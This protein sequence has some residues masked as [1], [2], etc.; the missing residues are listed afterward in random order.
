[1]SQGISG[2]SAASSAAS[3]SR[4]SGSPWR[5]SSS[6][7]QISSSCLPAITLP[8]SRAASITTLA[9]PRPQ[10]ISARS[11]L[12]SVVK[13]GLSCFLSSS[14]RLAGQHS[15]VSFFGSSLPLSRYQSHSLRS[16]RPATLWP[17]VLRVWMY[18]SPSRRRRRATRAWARSRAG[19][20]KYWLKSSRRSQPDLLRFF[21]SGWSR[22]ASRVSRLARS[23]ISVSLFM[24]GVF[25]AQPGGGC[26]GREVY[27]T[28]PSLAAAVSPYAALG[29]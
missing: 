14:A 25:Q 12:K 20:S 10:A 22:R 7:S 15:S 2:R 5:S 23:L 27:R 29:L 26:Q 6:S 13:I 21:S 19:V 3:S 4:A 28:G 11:R 1:M 8:R 17:R 24:A 16:D 9:L 18:C